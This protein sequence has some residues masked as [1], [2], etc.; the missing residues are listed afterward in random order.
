MR[1]I[2]HGEKPLYTDEWLDIRLAGIELH[3][4]RHLEHRLIRMGHYARRAALRSRARQG[5]TEERAP[6]IY[7]TVPSRQ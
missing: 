1:W 2:V 4:G 5:V 6:G 7:V 3:G